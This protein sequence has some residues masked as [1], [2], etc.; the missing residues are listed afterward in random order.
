[1]IT[2]YSVCSLIFILNP[3]AFASDSYLNVGVVNLNGSIVDTA[4]SIE[5]SSRN[6]YISMGEIPLSQ[7]I[8][9]GKGNTRDFEIKLINCVLNSNDGNRWNKFYITFDGYSK[10]DFFSV[11][12]DAKGI[13]LKLTDTENKIIKPGK[14][15]S[16]KLSGQDSYILNYKITLVPNNE[17]LQAGQYNS[18]I[19]F[20]LNYF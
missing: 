11:N 14:S 2:K 1:M 7:I 10:N 6:Q 4:C 5:T 12:G 20:H 15:L 19:R 17:N 3:L 16:Y 9:D 8:R 18:T 13:S